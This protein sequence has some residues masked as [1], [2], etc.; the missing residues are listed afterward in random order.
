MKMKLDLT[1][2]GVFEILVG[3]SDADVQYSQRKYQE[4][5]Y[6]YHQD[7]DEL[8]G[9]N[10]DVFAEELIKYYKEKVLTNK[11]SYFDKPISECSDDELSRWYVHFLNGADYYHDPIA[12]Y[13]WRI[14][15]KELEYRGE[16]LNAL[17]DYL[18]EVL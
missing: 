9:F 16:D 17:C 8:S 13:E 12:I 18:E 10:D 5:L 1:V 7:D 11:F 6:W 3:L 2:L 15:K 14:F 4:T